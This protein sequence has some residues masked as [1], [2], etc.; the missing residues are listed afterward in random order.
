MDRVGEW[1]NERA[2]IESTEWSSS[3]RLYND[4]ESW[5]RKHGETPIAY[6]SFS[7]RLIDRGFIQKRRREAGFPKRGFLGWRLRGLGEA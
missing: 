5:A 4:Y 2:V 1:L 7:A 6:T 3:E